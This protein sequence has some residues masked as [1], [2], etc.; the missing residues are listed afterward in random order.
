MRLAK[1]GFFGAGVAGVR[2]GVTGTG[3]VMCFLSLEAPEA[4]RHQGND[5]TTK[6]GVPERGLESDVDG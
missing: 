4:V 5:Q 3:V 1:E 2:P 6:L